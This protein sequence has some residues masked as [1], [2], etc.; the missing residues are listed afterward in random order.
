MF[1][2]LVRSG[3][4]HP[5]KVDSSCSISLSIA[6]GIQPNPIEDN[7]GLKIRLKMFVTFLNRTKW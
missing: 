5:Q 2:G 7:G 6:I 3:N 1:T 4:N